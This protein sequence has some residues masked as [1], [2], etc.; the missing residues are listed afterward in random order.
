MKNEAGFIT[1]Q[2]GR[3]VSPYFF[4]DK[5]LASREA[6]SE[7][8]LNGVRPLQPG[9]S[10]EEFPTL[11]SPREPGWGV[12]GLK[13]QNQISRKVISVSSLGMGMTKTGFRMRCSTFSATLPRKAWP[14]KPWLWVP[15]ITMSQFTLSTL[16]RISVAGSP[17]TTRMETTRFSVS[18]SFFN[19]R[20]AN[21]SSRA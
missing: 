8:G 21:S 18:G 20:L 6:P 17:S 15:I 7:R 16:S 11:R 19:S 2:I 9:K 3:R 4:G 1:P 10:K 13:F 12:Q 14:I 5:S